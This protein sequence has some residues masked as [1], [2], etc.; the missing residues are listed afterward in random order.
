M[1]E[2]DTFCIIQHEVCSYFH[3]EPSL[4]EM[5]PQAEQKL[6]QVLSLRATAVSLS[7]LP[8]PGKAGLVPGLKLPQKLSKPFPLPRRAWFC[9]SSIYFPIS[10][11]MQKKKKILLGSSRP[12]V[13][14]L[15]SFSSSTELGMSL[16]FSLRRGVPARHPGWG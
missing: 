2:A 3:V 1:E 13:H 14:R 6:F 16:L 7:L 9:R 10:A 5:H 4:T 12:S 8:S 15:S 11:Y